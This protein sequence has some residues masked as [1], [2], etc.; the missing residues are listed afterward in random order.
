MGENTQ[1][2]LRGEEHRT[3]WQGGEDGAD[4]SASGSVSE[5]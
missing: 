2:F 1:V 5:R 3:V 4:E